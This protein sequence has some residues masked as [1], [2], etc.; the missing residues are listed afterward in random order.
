MIES[1]LPNL[2]L[3]QKTIDLVY[4]IN[5]F[6]ETEHQFTKDITEKT[7]KYVKFVIERY[8]QKS[9]ESD[10][11]VNH[12]QCV[13]SRSQTSSL[14]F[15]PDWAIDRASLQA[16]IHEFDSSMKNLQLDSVNM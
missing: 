13:E 12:Q 16:A 8:T 2:L 7:L 9:D 10:K 14:Q 6:V 3:F 1:E 11:S 15:S 5:K 4:Q